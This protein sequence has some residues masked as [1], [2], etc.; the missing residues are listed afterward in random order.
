MFQA[1]FRI[2]EQFSIVRSSKEWYNFPT[3]Q[4]DYVEKLCGVCVPYLFHAF[5]N[6]VFFGLHCSSVTY[7]LIATV[8]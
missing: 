7:F 3:R 2:K 1:V 8:M 6:E 4:E 5:N